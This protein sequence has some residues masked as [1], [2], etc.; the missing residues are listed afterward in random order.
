MN[1]F[2]PRTLALSGV[3]IALNVVLSRLVS[4]PLGTTLR[5][6]VAQVPVILAG[7]WFGPLIG[8]L[9]GMIGDMIGTAI[10]GY[11]PNPFILVSATCV[12]IIPALLAPYIRKNAANSFYRFL[13]FLPVIALT[14]LITSQGLT[15]LGLSV[16]YGMP[17]EATF[18]TRLP[19]SLF[20]CTTNSCL[21]AL[22]YDRVRAEQFDLA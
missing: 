17:F 12:G 19:Q 8:G 2:S 6:S 21:C 13:R 14:M 9:T 16:M 1:H 20:L 7:I 18:L 5:I 4:I 11:A 10:N 15:T 3:L 22:I